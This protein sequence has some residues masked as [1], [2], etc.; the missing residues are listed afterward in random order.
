VPITSL[1]LVHTASSARVST[2]IDALDAMLGGSG[3]FEGSTILVSGSAGTGKSILG[4]TFANAT[5]QR[6]ARCL[7]FAFE[8][9]QHQIVRNMTS[10]GMT[11]APWITQ[12]LLTFSVARPSLYGLEM[13]LAQMHRQVEE[14]SPAVVVLDPLTSL[15][16][17]GAPEEVSALTTRLIDFLKLRGITALMTTL[18]PQFTALS[19]AEVGVSSLTDTWISLQDVPLG[20]KRT[21]TLSIVKSRGMAHA[22]EAREFK[23]TDRGIRLLSEAGPEV[24]SAMKQGSLQEV[25]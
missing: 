10:T 16:V 21:R 20:M 14:L 7:Y 6:G 1:G 23:I 22:V 4:A 25:D 24:T 3:F 18:A 19:S 5:C 11:L 17:T 15:S 8:E 12:G 2:G 13:H 9:S